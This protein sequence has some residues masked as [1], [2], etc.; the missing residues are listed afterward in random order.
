MKPTAHK[1]NDRAKSILSAIKRIFKEIHDARRKNAHSVQLSSQ[2]AHCG[3]FW[4]QSKFS[5]PTK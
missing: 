1:T 2:K 4:K 5:H 3:Y